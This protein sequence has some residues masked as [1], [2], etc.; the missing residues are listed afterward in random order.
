MVRVEKNMKN[1]PAEEIESTFWSM[2]DILRGKVDMNESYIL[3]LYLSLYKDELLS[4]VC[5][6]INEDSAPDLAHR[7]AKKYADKL[8]DNKKELSKY[9]D[10]IIQSLFNSLV[11]IDEPEIFKIAEKLKELEDK[12]EIDFNELKGN[13]QFIDV[14][15][16]A[17]TLALKTNEKKKIECFRNAIL[18]TAIGDSPDNTKSQIFLNQLDKFTSWH[19][20][21]LDFIDSPNEWFKKMG[22]TQPSFM[23]GSLHS[24]IIAAFPELKK[25]DE[26]LDIIWNDLESTGFHKSGGLK[27]MMSGNGVLSDRTTQLGREFLEF[28][29]N[30]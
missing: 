14:V 28:I 19:I 27:T 17:T 16:Q 30:N 29:S 10:S 18:N 15:L 25:Q 22:K 6:L 11:K 8:P 24:A 2:F 3:L 23:M 12:Q 1:S 20:V 4:K 21:I 7:L 13:E 5:T 9:Y 26:L